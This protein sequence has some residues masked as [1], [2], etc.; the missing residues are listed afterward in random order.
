[1]FDRRFS[2]GSYEYSALVQGEKGTRVRL[3]HE[4]CKDGNREVRSIALLRIPDKRLFL[5]TAHFTVGDLEQDD[6]FQVGASV[7]NGEAYWDNFS[8]TQTVLAVSGAA[9]SSAAD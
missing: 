5:I 9:E 3:L 2:N 8:L 6:Y 4:V 1:M 7:Q